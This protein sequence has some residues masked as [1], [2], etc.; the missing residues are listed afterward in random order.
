MALD[1]ILQESGFAPGAFPL[2]LG[3]WLAELYDRTRG[4]PFGPGGTPGTSNLTGVTISAG[5]AWVVFAD[6]TG[7]SADGQH[8]CSGT[9]EG[10][11]VL[12]GGIATAK[13]NYLAG[14]PRGDL[15]LALDF[16][17]SGTRVD[18]IAT[19]AGVAS[20]TST[21]KLRP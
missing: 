21:V 10:L 3:S 1:E 16:S 17:I 19:G 18:V 9:L 8:A 6:V 4:I 13:G 14:P 7:I 5:R 15:P 2:P 11:F 20:W 12:V